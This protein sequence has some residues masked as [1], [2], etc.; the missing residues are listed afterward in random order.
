MPPQESLLPRTDAIRKQTVEVQKYGKGWL[1]RYKN[2]DGFVKQRK[3]SNA[4]DADPYFWE[5]VEEMK[6]RIQGGS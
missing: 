3:F 4:N 5:C 2:C 1:V 6:N